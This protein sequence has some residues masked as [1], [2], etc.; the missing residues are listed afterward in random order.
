L[1]IGLIIALLSVVT[2]FADAA[3]Y[4]AQEIMRTRLSSSVVDWPAAQAA[5]AKFEAVGPASGGR[6]PDVLGRLNAASGRLL[7]N[8]AASPVP[9]LLPLD[10]LALLRDQANASG[11][12]QPAKS[13]RYFAGF[14]APRFFLPGPAGYDATFTIHTADIAELA[15]ISLPDPV[16]I[17]ISGLAFTYE[18]DQQTPE[19]RPVPAL[20]GRFPGIKRLMQEGHLRYAFVQ[21]GV[22][23]V[24]SIECFD[25]RPR[26]LRL[27]CTQ[28]DRIALHFLNLLNI[29]GG[30]PRSAANVEPPVVVRPPTMSA[31]FSYFGPGR[32]YSGSGFHSA[33]GRVDYT[34]FA[35][36]RFPLADSPAYANSQIY[37]DRA[38]AKLSV[39]EAAASPDYAYPWR[40]NFCERRGFPVGQCF[41]GIGHQGQDIRP[42]PCPAPL[43]NDRCDPAH[44]VVA[45]RDGAIMRSPKQEAVYVVINIAN[46]HVRFRYLHMEPRRMD[47]DNLLSGRDV[48][49]GEVIGQVSN[50]SRKENGTS[51]HLHFD[52]QVPT[53]TGWVFVN[54]YMTLVTAYERLIGGRGVEI[55]DVPQ[56]AQATEIDS[57][58]TP[59]P[60][61][62]APVD[63]HR[64]IRRDEPK[65]TNGNGKDQAGMNEF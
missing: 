51:Y 17:Q 48:R 36:I 3:A 6:E 15:D 18:V 55:V 41:A 35:P 23:Y 20:E 54:P 46:E 45:A 57:G 39:R 24:L 42:A 32:I 9:V 50:F 60:A 47:E 40:D 29:A 8:I 7:S 53:R 65:D 13:E 64:K 26:L 2:G 33:G 56:A 31:T 28:A 5:L 49:E 19:M 62:A 38:R 58:N 12:A 11:D 63:K 52:V 34:V 22:P 14:H 59:Q 37:R 21:F 27:I 25:G 1:R 61:S 44:N 4:A 16:E 10:V 30:T 43:G